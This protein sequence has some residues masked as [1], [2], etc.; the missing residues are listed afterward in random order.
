VK[1]AETILAQ[2]ESFKAQFDGAIKKQKVAGT[3]RVAFE[4]A[5]QDLMDNATGKLAALFEEQHH[6]T[7]SEMT[8]RILEANDA[9]DAIVGADF[10]YRTSVIDF[11]I[12]SLTSL[13]EDFESTV[14]SAQTSLE[15]A[16][17]LIASFEIGPDPKIEELRTLLA[18][19]DSCDL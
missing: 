10:G 4:K 14:A 15:K 13:A 18:R 5:R 17:E 1:G 12:G 2:F 8:Q 19:L 3:N 6:K 11:L 16:Q 9:R 7:K